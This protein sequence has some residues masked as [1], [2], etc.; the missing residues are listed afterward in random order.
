MNT[1]APHPLRSR[2]LQWGGSALEFALNRVLA[3]DSDTQQA[4]HRLNG[5]SIDLR[6]D[7]PVLAARLR[8]ENGR[9]FVGPT[10]EAE[11]DL[12]LSATAGALLARL[13]PSQTSNATPGKLRISGDID[14]AQQVQKLAQQFAPDLEEALSQRLGDVLGVQVARALRSAGQTAQQIGKTSVTRVVEYVRDERGD[15]LGSEEMNAFLDEVD[16]LRDSAERLAQRVEQFKRQVDGRY[17][18][19]D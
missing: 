19:S 8:V 4:L 14:L 3:L 9:L 10:D 7:A 18:S 1:S 13:L 12:S 6:L 15:V 2:I 17:P 5:R 11:S 16:H